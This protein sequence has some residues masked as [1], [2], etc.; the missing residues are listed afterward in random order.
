[1][2]KILIKPEK[3]THSKDLFDYRIE[4]KINQVD[5]GDLKSRK[6]L[7]DFREQTYRHITIVGDKASK[8]IKEILNKLPISARKAN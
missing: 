2:S 1:M 8:K 5:Y 3:P 4:L 6:E 7:R